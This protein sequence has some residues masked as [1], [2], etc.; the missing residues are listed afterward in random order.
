[1]VVALPA[2]YVALTPHLTG[3]VMEASGGLDKVAGVSGKQLW[4]AGGVSPKAR[5]WF[6]ANGWTV[7]AE[8]RERLLSAGR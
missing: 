3:V 2:D 6:E 5:G 4:I 7:R 8:A 1:V